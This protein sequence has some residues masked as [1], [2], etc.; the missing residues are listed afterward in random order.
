MKGNSMTNDI[1]E[2]FNLKRWIEE[3]EDRLKPPTAAETILRNEKY[4]VTVIGGPNKRN[5]FHVN[6][7][8]EFFYQI[9]GA[10]T[11][12]VQEKGGPRDIF[13]DEGQIFLLPPK[14]PH[15]PQ[16]PANT[17]GLVLESVRQPEELDTHRWY[18]GNC[19]HLLFEK[20]AYLEVLERDMPPIFEAYYSDK[21]NQKCANCGFLNAGRL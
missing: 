6:Q 2:S 12:R 20:S 10:I 21:S 19:N 8:S 9:R 5:D 4:M 17:I 14:T 11:L 1:L 16:R 7:G 18:C 3:N 15:A 13:I